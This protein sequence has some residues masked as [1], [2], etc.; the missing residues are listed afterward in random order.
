MGI[1]TKKGD[2]GQTSLLSG[3]RVWKSDSLVKAYGALDELSSVIGVARA[4]PPDKDGFGKLLLDIQKDLWIM[5]AQLASRPPFWPR[6]KQRIEPG[7]ISR[8]EDRIDQV[9]DRFGQPNFF[10]M[11][12]NSLKSAYLHQARTVCRRCERIVIMSSEKDDDY[13]LIIAYLNRLSDFLF[14]LAWAQEVKD[15]VC[16]VVGQF[17]SALNAGGNHA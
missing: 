14:M 3:E 17:E 15:A 13:D 4:L 8:L 12:G 10:V 6:L 5:A 9:T 2:Q 1:Y 16:R 7:N 11:P